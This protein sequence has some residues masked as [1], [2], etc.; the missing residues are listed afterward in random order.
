ML[1][2]ICENPFVLKML[3]FIGKLVKICYLVIPIG[4]VIFFSFDF[5]KGIINQEEAD[6]Q[7]VFSLKKIINVV[8]LFLV[9]TF[10]SIFMKFISNIEF[11]DI[12]YKTCLA[13][14]SNITYYEEKYESLIKLEEE[15]RAEEIEKQLAD[16][17]Y[18][19][20]LDRRKKMF[21][22]Y[23]EKKDNNGGNN[24]GGNTYD[25][26]AVFTG[27]TYSLSADELKNITAVCIGEQGAYVDGV[28]SEASFMANTYEA[29]Y[30]NKF[31]T[32]SSWVLDTGDGHYFDTR[33]YENGLP[34]VTDELINAVKEVLVN[35][36][37]TLPLYVDDHDCWFCSDHYDR[38]H[39]PLYCHNGNKGDI[40][41]LNN[42]GSDLSS[43]DEIT[44][45]DNYIKDKT[46]IYTYYKQD[47]SDDLDKYFIFYAWARPTTK[48]GDPFG[49]TED[50]YKRING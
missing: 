15:K 44:N 23:N 34:Q 42:G 30:S 17:E 48:G 38:N 20:T 19:K 29:K 11:L 12:N 35:G 32:I 8:A 5:F 46:K 14:T 31:S 6:K 22:K 7:I 27:Q 26:S 13:N 45:R 41:Y 9:P 33:S 25:P 49:Y 3:L 28:S 47:H 4:L 50:T 21:V 2:G 39:N 40:C 1:V 18:Y 36:N 24:T 10:V 16:Y 37:R 43:K